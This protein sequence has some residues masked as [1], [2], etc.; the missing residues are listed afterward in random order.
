MG[1]SRLGALCEGCSAMQCG[2]RARDQQCKASARGD[3]GC[4][5]PNAP[6][7]NLAVVEGCTQS[8]ANSA[9]QLGLQEL[10]IESCNDLFIGTTWKAL[11]SLT[12]LTRLELA[13]LRKSILSHP[14]GFLRWVAATGWPGP[15]ESLLLSPD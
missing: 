14:T 11:A 1:M 3:S 8:A 6:Q 5:P 13:R 9:G 7:R 12:S 10:T 2:D 4:L 15:A